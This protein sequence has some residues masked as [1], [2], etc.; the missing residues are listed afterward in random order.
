MKT[1]NVVEPTHHPTAPPAKG[2]AVLRTLGVY[3]N[4]YEHFSGL[5]RSCYDCGVYAMDDKMFAQV[6]DALVVSYTTS[7]IH[8]KLLDFAP[9]FSAHPGF[10]CE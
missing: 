6:H 10:V 8:M 7:D 3:V 9:F 5:L 4:S 1:L 2:G